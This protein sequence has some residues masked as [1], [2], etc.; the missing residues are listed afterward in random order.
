MNKGLLLAAAL[1]AGSVQT[2]AQTMI[3]KNHIQ[4]QSDCMTPAAS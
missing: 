2:E 3:S 4:L 1:L